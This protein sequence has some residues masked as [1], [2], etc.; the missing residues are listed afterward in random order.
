MLHQGQVAIIA[1]VVLLVVG[2]VLI[3]LGWD[4]AASLDYVQG[5]FP[6]LLSASVPGIALIII[7]MS[8]LVLAI[9]RKDAAERDA[10]LERLAA[11]L[12][13]LASLVA[14]PDPYD[15]TLSGEYRPR[16][17]VTSNGSDGDAATAEIGQ[18]ADFEQGR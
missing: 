9:I 2:G 10:Q 4:G 7:G 5:Q 18:P 3:T 16:P 15:P 13:E 11:S 12:N 1:G 14:P 8:V 17:R 6:Y